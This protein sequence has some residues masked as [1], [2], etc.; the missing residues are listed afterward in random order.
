MDFVVDVVVVA[1][2]PTKQQLIEHDGYD[3]D[4]DVIE[5]VENGD[6]D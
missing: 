4:Y 3:D 1:Y 2:R 5:V 6:D